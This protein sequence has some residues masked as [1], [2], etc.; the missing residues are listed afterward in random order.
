M[1]GLLRCHDA[2]AA[3]EI[4]PSSWHDDGQ[5]SQAEDTLQAYTKYKLYHY[6]DNIE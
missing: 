6:R 4:L 1:V 5:H 2:P 3:K